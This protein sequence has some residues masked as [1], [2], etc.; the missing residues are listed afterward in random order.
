MM[1]VKKFLTK[2][3]KQF[4]NRKKRQS[5]AAKKT[6]ETAS[7]IKKKFVQK[8]FLYSKKMS[9]E[10]TIASKIFKNQRRQYVKSKNK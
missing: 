8:F 10:K 2:Q 7:L 9:F 6:I 4:R 5:N 1:R 3:L